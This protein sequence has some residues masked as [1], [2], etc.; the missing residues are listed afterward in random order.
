MSNLFIQTPESCFDK[1]EDFPY[2][3]NFMKESLGLSEEYKNFKIA[4]IDENKKGKKGV[5]LMIHGHPTWSYLWRHL[6]PFGLKND[7]RVIAIDLPGFGRSD[8]PKDEN[9]FN[10]D[11]Y[12]NIILSIIHN[13]NLKNITLFL[14]EWGGT[15][16]LT[17]P[18][19][20]ASK[21]NGMV[22]FN[23]YLG[24]SLSNIAEGYKNWIN[25]NI[26]TENLNVRAIMARTNRILNLSECNAYEAPYEDKTSKLSLRML[27]SIFP[28]NSNSDG[29]ELCKKALHW[30]EENSL[31]KV[32]VIGGGR[33]PLV[34]V[35]KMKSL[36]KIISTDEQTHVINNAGHFVPEWG[37]EFGEE[38]FEQ[39]VDE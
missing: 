22:V 9:F 31:N 32:L 18:I 3:A 35:E 2:I 27:P 16:G 23:S 34:P 29:F 8:K 28:I 12:R 37:M 6:I 38:L 15:L 1:I 20:D 33:D 10:F 13:L 7:Y 19:D 11:S 36:S 17:L 5:L 14:H 39:L 30:W 25:T 21:Y 4:Y 26:N 24:N